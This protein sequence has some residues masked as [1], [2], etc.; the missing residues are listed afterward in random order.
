MSNK[1]PL[2]FTVIIKHLCIDKIKFQLIRHFFCKKFGKLNNPPYL[3]DVK[4]ILQS[5]GAITAIQNKNIYFLTILTD[6][7][8][9]IDTRALRN[10]AKAIKLLDTYSKVE[11]TYG[12]TEN[13]QRVEKSRKDL[14]N[15][16]F[17]C[18]YD[19]DRET[20]RLF[21]LKKKRDLI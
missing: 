15:V 1:I 20:Y 12:T 10:I 8:M 7:I 13:V 2:C 4:M 19:F 21:K 3:C 11:T 17:S 16:I 18:G 5:Y 14:I 6:K 9:Y